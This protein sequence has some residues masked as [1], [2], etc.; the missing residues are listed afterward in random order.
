MSTRNR[1]LDK[2][3]PSRLRVR[4]WPPSR[5]TAVGAGFTNDLSAGGAYVETTTPLKSGS[6]LRLELQTGDGGFLVEAVV[7]RGVF[8]ARELQRVKKSGMAIRFLHIDDIVTRLQARPRPAKPEEIHDPEKPDV[9]ESEHEFAFL[10]NEE[11][12]EPMPGEV[13]RDLHA[14]T[15]TELKELQAFEASIGSGGRTGES[16]VASTTTKAPPGGAPADK[17]SDAVAAELDDLDLD[18]DDQPAVAAGP[19]A[20]VVALDSLPVAS[21]DAAGKALAATVRSGG[22]DPTAARVALEDLAQLRRIYD[23]E[24]RYGGMLLTT[25]DPMAR[26]AL[27]VELDLGEADGPLCAPASISQRYRHP[28]GDADGPR[29]IVQVLFDAPQELATAVERRLST[30][31]GWR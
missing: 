24:L 4:F 5:P 2:R 20:P 28:E 19:P 29:C 8:V 12:T 30:D 26:D 13:R 23:S 31:A 6:R 10:N 17:P 11:L 7:V 27:V 21:S 3:T 16:P 18:L 9:P 14:E 22:S 1:R 25:S 15:A